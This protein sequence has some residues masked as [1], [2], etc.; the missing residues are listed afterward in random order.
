MKIDHY[1]VSTVGSD[2]NLKGFAFQ[3]PEKLASIGAFVREVRTFLVKK[4]KK[5]HP[6]KFTQ[7]SV[8]EY[9]GYES[10]QYVYLVE[11]GKSEPSL[12]LLVGLCDYYGIPRDY[13]YEV[14]VEFK[15]RVIRKA[16]F[17]K[18]ARA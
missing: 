10:S 14:L 8:A 12:E 7:H 1:P 2:I 9:M 13:M 11:T 16:L 15:A 5:Q 18:K 17:G 6:Q 4:Y 3:A